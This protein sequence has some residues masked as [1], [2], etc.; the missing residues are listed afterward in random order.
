[1]LGQLL[2]R[3]QIRLD[4]FNAWIIS[5]IKAGPSKAACSETWEE[6]EM[7]D[8]VIEPR[9]WVLETSRTR[10]RQS[11]GGGNSGKCCRQ[12]RPSQSL[13]D[14]MTKST[15]S[16]L[17]AKLSRSKPDVTERRG[18]M[19]E[20]IKGIAA[21]VD[22]EPADEAGGCVT[23]QKGQGASLSLWSQGPRFGIG[24]GGAPRLSVLLPASPFAAQRASFSARGKTSTC[25]TGEV[26]R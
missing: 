20:R 11:T 14:C 23:L 4:T 17:L 5:V 18:V 25:G 8:N 2:L 6:V 19:S 26:L 24:T 9:D 10:C 3:R 21:G 7:S 16:T 1:V 12:C 13:G 22:A 15:T